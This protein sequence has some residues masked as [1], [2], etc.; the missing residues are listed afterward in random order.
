MKGKE[1]GAFSISHFQKVI[2]VFKFFK[3]NLQ[4]IPATEPVT[5]F[6]SAKLKR[7]RGYL[8]QEHRSEVAFDV[9]A[10]I[11]R[12]ACTECGQPRTFPCESIGCEQCTLTC[13][14]K[15]CTQSRA[16][17]LCLTINSPE[18]IRQ[19]Y[20][21]QIT[22]VFWISKHGNGSISPVDLEIMAGTIKDFLKRSKN[23]VVLLDGIEYLVTMN[24]F[25]TCLK[26]LYDMRE[27]VILDNAILILPVSS[28]AFEERENALLKK[29]FDKVDFD[30]FH[31]ERIF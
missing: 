22:P 10:S 31:D 6:D 23:P 17:G 13:P 15:Y 16:Q 18:D 7:G 26:F 11:I 27:L 8:I 9:F 1:K 20:L 24:G 21:L 28:A 3:R 2:E 25:I 12:G 5:N 29:I 30:I 19:R 14:C 4:V